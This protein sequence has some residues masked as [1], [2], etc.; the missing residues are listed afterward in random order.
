[1]KTKS[2]RSVPGTRAWDRPVF[3]DKYFCEKSGQTFD[4]IADNDLFWLEDDGDH[5]DEFA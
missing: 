3:F 5:G 2:K 1:M 4:I